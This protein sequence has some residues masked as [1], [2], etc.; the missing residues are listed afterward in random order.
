[1]DDFNIQNLYESKNEWGARLL[2]LLTPQIIDGF[3]S[4]F[5]EACN[6]CNENDEMKKY[7]MTF[8]NYITRIPNW[9]NELID[10]ETKRICSSGDCQY[11][12][13]LLTCVHII[14]LKI[15]TNVRVGQSAK[16][17]NINI[18][19]INNF[20]H[21][22]YILAGRKIYK[23][24]YLFE[25]NIPP[26]QIQ[27]NNRE[28]ELI[29]NE[30]ILS[31]IRESIPLNSLLKSYLDETCEEVVTEEI[32]NDIIQDEEL[33]DTDTQKT[34]E[35]L[36]VEKFVPPVTETNIDKDKIIMTIDEIKEIKEIKEPSIDEIKEIKE[37]SIDENKEPIIDIKNIEN[38]IKEP[39]IDIKNIENVIKE[40]IIDDNISETDID[41]LQINYDKPCNDSIKINFDFGNN[42]ADADTDEKQNNIQTNIMEKFNDEL[43]LNISP[44]EINL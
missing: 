16:K 44:L 41:T 17:V 42:D 38:V 26:L 27:K 1:M 4:I 20:I 7:L 29:I 22:V 37:P 11:L 32:Y 24:I 5:I 34:N 8:Q 13:D 36:V 18:P 9:N 19:K 14:Q 25:I 6:L 31:A 10:I 15:L 21:K 12:E 3:K 39:I 23:N 33:E 28:I 35:M 30:C 40:P 2:N 43:K